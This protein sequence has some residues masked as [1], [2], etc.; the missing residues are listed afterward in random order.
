MLNIKSVLAGLYMGAA[1]I[2]LSTTSAQAILIDNGLTTVD[3]DQNLVWL[4]LTESTGRS[5][6]D[7]ASQFGTG[8]DFE[9]WRH[10]TTSEVTTMFSNAG[11]SSSYISSPATPQMLTLVNL[12]GPTFTTTG[13]SGGLLINSWGWFDDTDPASASIGTAFIEHDA[14]FLSNTAFTVDRAAVVINSAGTQSSGPS[15]GSWL[16][17][18]STPIPEPT[19]LALLAA[20]LAGLGFARSR[21]TA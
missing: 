15:V 6:N 18:A 5:Y 2:G 21:R 8:G 13:P 17:R 9:G 12:F 7:V 14:S 10:A 19:P 4:D 3:T 11:F 1:A 20:G 16:V